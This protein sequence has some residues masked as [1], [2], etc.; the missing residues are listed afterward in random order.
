MT[1][2]NYRVRSGDTL[3]GI[4]KKNGTT[5]DTIAKANGIDN[6]N[7]I[8]AGQS[9]K[10]PDGFTPSTQGTTKPS[11]DYTV[12][13]GDTLSELAKKS[14]TSVKALATA[15]GI[16]NANKIKVGQKL[17]L[18]K[19]GFDTKPAP[20]KPQPAPAKPQ[21]P[22]TAQTPR[23]Q[24]PTPSTPTTPKPTTTAPTTT[25]GTSSI[26]NGYKN[27]DLKDFLSTE[28]GTQSLAAI[29][30]G[31]AE[32][33]RTPNGGKT[34]AFGGHQDPGNA[35]HNLGSFSYQDGKVANATAADQAQLRAM[36][37]K[38]GDYTKA[39]KAAGLDPNNALLASAFFDSYNQSKTAA[40]RF[41][42]QLPYLKENGV[43]PKTVTEARVRSWVDPNTGARYKTA[44]GNPV[45]GG[46]ENIARKQA[47]KEGRPFR[48]ESDVIATIR[49][50]QG[51]RVNEMV[52]ALKAQ[53]LAGA[54]TTTAP[55]KPTT[56]STPTQTKPTQPKPTTPTTTPTSPSTVKGK[57]IPDTSKMTE[58]QKFDVYAKYFQDKG[59]KLNT[60]PG[61]RTILGLREP[62]NMNTNNGTGAYDDRIAV[63][64][65][66]KQGNKHV[67]E[68]Q[69]NTEPNEY[70]R[71]Q[72]YG[73]D[74]DGKN[75]NDMGQ[76][77]DGHYE[78]Q[79][80]TGY[81]GWLKG[82]PVLRPTRPVDTQHDVNHD[83]MING[84]DAKKDKNL[85]AM[86]MLFHAGSNNNTGSAGCQ[87]MK[88]SDYK[89]FWDSLGD[90]KK[91]NYLLVTVK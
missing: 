88:G 4:A 2:I 23:P 3:S 82:K 85:P 31:N 47:A 20:A 25:S 32:G 60:N 1:S 8:K 52:K 76:I 69:A 42:K 6:P 57:G 46:L 29:V 28:K 71:K 59:V 56:P 73:N 66:D 54:P 53:G 50:D 67:Q 26:N 65:T 51:R 78:Y 90:D 15:N 33:T 68:F 36:Q 30:I 19:D 44:K 72:G 64:W 7:K 81:T 61:E 14:G 43:T 80:S 55:T 16:E 49:A 75:G 11:K 39:A 24:T 79:K 48:G 77:A 5:V 38:M 84:A 17:T 58:A 18:P 34:K 62:T 9:L 63:L 12:R 27:V 89:R 83:G 70:Y 74:V 87:T 13:A 41:L 21:T 10:I 45:G 35:K 86:D 40:D 22:T 37:N 91:F